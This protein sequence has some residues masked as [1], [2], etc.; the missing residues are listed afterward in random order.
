MA[1]VHKAVR[2]TLTLQGVHPQ[3]SAFPLPVASLWFPS[4]MISE[5]VFA[6]VAKTKVTLAL[7][8]RKQAT[9]TSTLAGT[10]SSVRLVLF[11]PVTGRTDLSALKTW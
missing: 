8:T 9:R 3:Q 4:R 10:S 1:A 2:H 7:P 5:S 6:L 11:C